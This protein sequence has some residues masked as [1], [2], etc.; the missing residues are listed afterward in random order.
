[1]CGSWDGVAVRAA[2]AGPGR[3]SKLRDLWLRVDSARPLL[4]PEDA[5]IADART[6][7][8]T[9]AVHTVAITWYCVVSQIVQRP[10]GA[11]C[12][13][14]HWFAIAPADQPAILPGRSDS[15]PKGRTADSNRRGDRREPQQ[16]VVLKK[17]IFCSRCTFSRGKHRHCEYT[18]ESWGCE[19]HSPIARGE[20]PEVA[21]SLL[22]C[23]H[24]QYK[25]VERLVL[26]TSAIAM[27]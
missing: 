23:A 9:Q 2:A 24:S 13:Q 25:C 17:I 16:L 4:D 11:R 26:G 21:H 6:T 18:Q 7:V 20:H 15:A 8:H 1:M 14:L 10:E 22:T 19:H 3:R 27:S 5:D 12:V